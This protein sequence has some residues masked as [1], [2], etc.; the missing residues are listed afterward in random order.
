MYPNFSYLEIREILHKQGVST[1]L[2]KV[3]MYCAVCGE[4]VIIRPSELNK[5]RS[6]RCD[7]HRRKVK[8]GQEHPQYKRCELTC[9]Y[10]G[11]KFIGI[12]SKA[13]NKNKYG[14]THVFCSHE[15]YG[16]FRSKYYVGEKSAM[17]R[18]KYT[19]EQIENLS[20]GCAKR[21]KN[22]DRLNTS[23]QKKV[24][25]MLDRLKIK[26]EREKRFDF[27][28]CDNYINDKQLIIEVMG[29][30]WH[31]NPERYN[32]NGRTLNEIQRKTILKDK[33]KAGYI[34][35]H[36]GIPILYLW[37]SDINKSPEKCIELI[38]QFVANPRMPNYHSFN[39][40]FIDGNLTL[41]KE[42]LVPYQNMPSDAYK[43]L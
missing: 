5:G 34:S 11:K 35:S 20:K 23:I 1:K 6:F 26:Y 37:E 10:C 43:N 16:K 27:Y 12:P 15:C 28:A 22:S 9:S 4:E 2:M 32:K 24:D 7:E 40:C 25:E 39:Y 8:K 13:K 30:Y 19:P 33:Q 41:S 14:D 38:R 29:D 18:H 3:R 31:A 36:Y 21:A 42:L 17:Y